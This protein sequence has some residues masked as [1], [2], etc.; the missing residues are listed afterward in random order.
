MAQGGVSQSIAAQAEW[1]RPELENLVLD[2]SVFW[3]RINVR[4][5]IKPVSNRPA[6]I[7]FQVATG[8][9]PKVAGFDGQNLGRGSAPIESPGTLSCVSFLQASE[10]TALAE[11][12]TDSSE[13]AIQNFVT[14]THEQAA[15]CFGGFLDTLA[16]GD[17]SN[18][19]DTVVS[20]VTNGLVVNNAD[21]F[22]DQ[23]YVDAWTAVGGTFLGTVQI[24]SV[25]IANNTIWLTGAVPAGIT[26]GTVLMA[27]GS[28]GQANSGLFGLGYYQVSGNVGNYMGISRAAWPGK[29][30]TPLI[31]LGGKALTP[32]VVRALQSQQ[33][34]ALGNDND[35]K[36][37]VAHC[38]VDV[39][40][41]W[42]NN[43][44]NVQSIIRNQVKGDES[45]DMLGKQPVTT[46]AGR[47]VLLNV[48]ATP[49]IL[50]FLDLST[51]FIIQTR[52]ND[53]YD[54]GGQTIFPA[55]GNDGGIASSMMF[56]LAIVA[57]L[58]NGQPRKG[59]RCTNIAPVSNLFGH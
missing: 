46:I 47:E 12:S 40:N 3:K 21:K 23:W 45:T 31:N 7:P 54:V 15:D 28:S 41:A 4:T 16:Q 13:K 9:R 11:W 52:A 18:T 37:N 1:L 6:R 53:L 8:G 48:R 42:E 34:L 51:W 5:D 58:G 17:G 24:Q 59:A 19:L 38:N 29:F 50:D 43:A 30:S 33:I 26:T 14:L 20:T 35:G 55:Y 2:S 22:G 10:Y 39:Q 49:G 36:N 56:Y 44:L 32:A 25:D 57:Q 27:E